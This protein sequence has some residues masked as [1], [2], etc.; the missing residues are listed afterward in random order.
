MRG[1]MTV[2][3]NTREEQAEKIGARR[4][5]LVERE[6]GLRDLRMDGEQAGAGGR[7]STRSVDEIAEARA[8]TKASG[9]GVDSCCI[10]WLSSERRVCV[11]TS[12][13]IF[14]SIAS[15]ACGEIERDRIAGPNLRMNKTCA[16]S[17]A[18]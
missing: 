15:A 18:S 7:L 5:K 13:A 16:A 11:G 6:R 1:V 14:V 10:A 3:R 8:A 17:S 9:N 12:C 4:G 2:S